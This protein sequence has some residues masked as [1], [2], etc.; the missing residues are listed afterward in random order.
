MSA[1]RGH[2]VEG[3]RMFR[4]HIVIHPLDVEVF[5]DVAHRLARQITPAI[6]REAVLARWYSVNS[7]HGM[8]TKAFWIH[9]EN[10]AKLRSLAAALSSYR[11]Q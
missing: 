2:V 5:T 9:R 10:E 8:R 11:E 3:V 7:P 6:P 4:L 1:R